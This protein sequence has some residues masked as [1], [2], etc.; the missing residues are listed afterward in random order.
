MADTRCVAKINLLSNR[1][2]KLL[3]VATEKEI[4]ELEE[5]F[6]GGEYGKRL[7]GNSD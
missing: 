4:E 2:I 5:L 6:K 7:E 1:L 3:K